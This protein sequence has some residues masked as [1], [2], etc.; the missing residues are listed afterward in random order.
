MHP[1][2]YLIPP[3]Y[4][5][6]LHVQFRQKTSNISDI[7]VSVLRKRCKSETDHRFLK[8]KQQGHRTKA[9]IK[10]TITITAL[11]IVLTSWI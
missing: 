8:M 10:Q 5:C 7:S 4:A 2:V 11:F 9:E 3:L 6:L 1:Y